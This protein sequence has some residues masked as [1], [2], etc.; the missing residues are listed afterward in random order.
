M[1]IYIVKVINGVNEVFHLSWYFH[2]ALSFGA[3]LVSMSGKLL[4]IGNLADRLGWS[5]DILRTDTVAMSQL[6][7]SYFFCHVRTALQTKLI[8]QLTPGSNISF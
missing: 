2:S 6:V 7:S 1:A 8:E 5:V 4:Y 3:A